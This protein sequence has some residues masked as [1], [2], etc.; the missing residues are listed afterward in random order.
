MQHRMRQAGKN[1]H[2]FKVDTISFLPWDKYILE[3]KNPTSQCT[4][5]VCLTGGPRAVAVASLHAW[6]VAGQAPT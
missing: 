1:D 5:F 3:H 6:P 2:Q 4:A